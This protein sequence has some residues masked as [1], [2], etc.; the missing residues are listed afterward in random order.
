MSSDRKLFEAFMVNGTVEGKVPAEVAKLPDWKTPL[1]IGI[2][3]GIS[4]SNQY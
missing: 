2:V 4:S 1:S 3:S